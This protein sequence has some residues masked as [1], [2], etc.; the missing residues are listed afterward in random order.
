M[1]QY[2]VE[3][4]CIAFLVVFLFSFRAVFAVEQ[5]F[6][7][8]NP[9]WRNSHITLTLSRSLDSSSTI[10][11]DLSKVVRRSLSAWS[12]PTNITFDLADSELQS[13]SPKGNQGDGISLITVAVTPENLK[14]FPR[15][16]ASA[17]AVTR[18]FTDSRGYI[19]EADIVLNPFVR[20][21]TDGAYD[22]FDLQDTLTHEIGHLL[23]LE[24]LPVW[25]SMMYERGAR[26]LGPSSFRGSRNDLP[27]V[28]ASSIKGLYG[29]RPEEVRCCGAIVGR[30]VG[31]K[32]G[33]PV[34]IW[35]EEFETG[36]LIAATVPDL[37]G[38]YRLEG[39]PEGEFS[40][41]ASSESRSNEFASD[42]SK[43]SVAI[44][45][46]TRRNFALRYL[47]SGMSVQMIGTSL[48]LGRLPIDLT[49]SSQGLFLGFNG[50]LSAVNRVIATG[51]G[52]GFEAKTIS[53]NLPRF[54]S[55]KVVGFDMTI[56]PDQ[57]KGEYTLV[58]EGSAGVRQYIVGSLI[59]RE[60]A[61]S[62]SH[63]CP[64]AIRL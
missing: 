64:K 50:D 26:S 39:I 16:G 54:S 56:Q 60:P 2:R 47:R 13:V 6:I 36:R 14:L 46:E 34:L 63:H 1:E 25:G 10:Q 27:K 15:Q 62:R 7:P 8:K 40:I 49:P 35:I 51:G 28:D 58:I 17:A 59:I 53:D 42:T 19:T 29:P 20:F 21:S 48:Q 43:I 37:D 44:A 31:G 18:V 30:V 32:P 41:H 4:R 24:H 38:S 57:P 33:S 23:G 5:P 11:A 55:V 52:L 9:K 61:E 3:A 45:E 12:V 22:T